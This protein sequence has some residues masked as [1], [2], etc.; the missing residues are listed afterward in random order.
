MEPS[1]PNETP[2]KSGIL[3]ENRG[4]NVKSVSTP[5][6]GSMKKKSRI[7]V[8][9][10]PKTPRDTNDVLKRA[11]EAKLNNTA[12]RRRHVQELRETWAKESEKSRQDNLRAKFYFFD[13]FLSTILKIGRTGGDNWN[14][15]L[16]R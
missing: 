5:Q 15:D 10:T 8:C 12:E 9:K 11:R 2:N 16:P 1:T 3:S 4:S 14:K 13:I 6:N 7:P